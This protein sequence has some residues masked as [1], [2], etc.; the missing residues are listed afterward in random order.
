MALEKSLDKK[1]LKGFLIVSGVVGVGIL[2][3]YYG[4]LGNL[5]N[6]LLVLYIGVFIPLALLFEG[7]FWNTIGGIFGFLFFLFAL[8]FIWIN[9]K[10]YGPL[11][12]MIFSMIFLLLVAKNIDYSD[13]I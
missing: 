4:M 6:T 13:Y 9:F 1:T 8:F 11:F 5:I 7:G 3:F 10:D 12:I 2:L